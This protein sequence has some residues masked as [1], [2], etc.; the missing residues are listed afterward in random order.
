ALSFGS[1]SN[2][3][4]VVAVESDVVALSLQDGVKSVEQH[5]SKKW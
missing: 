4:G 5:V 2:G 3:S 1:D